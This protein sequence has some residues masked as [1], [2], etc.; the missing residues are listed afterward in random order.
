[1]EISELY[2]YG[3]HIND[4]VIEI[5]QEMGEYLA[6]TRFEDKLLG[7]DADISDDHDESA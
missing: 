4:E 7:K 3:G 5:A 1:M 2:G 6:W